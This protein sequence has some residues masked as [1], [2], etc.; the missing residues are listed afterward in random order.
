MEVFVA[1]NGRECLNIVT[2]VALTSEVDEGTT[3]TANAETFEN[4]LGKLLVNAWESYDKDTEDSERTI[5]V[6]THIKNDDGP[7][8]P[9]IDVID[10]G[11]GISDEV[12]DTLFEPFITTKTSVG[13]GMGLTIARHTLRNLEGDVRLKKND[14]GGVTATMTHPL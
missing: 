1:Y 5:R 8:C 7:P 13:R 12:K 3:I 10:Q 2:E 6:L 4:I 9:V 11:L 14:S